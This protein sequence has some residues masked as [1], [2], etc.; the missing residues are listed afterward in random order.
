VD[1]YT[2]LIDEMSE[3]KHELRLSEPY[4]LVLEWRWVLSQ[5]PSRHTV[6]LSSNNIYCIDKFTKMC[7]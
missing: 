5:V 6:R 2:E 7:F 4:G 3:L 1:W